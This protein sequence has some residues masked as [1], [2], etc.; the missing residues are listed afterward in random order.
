MLTFLYDVILS[1]QRK[2][3][4]SGFFFRPDERAEKGKQFNYQS[5]DQGLK[6]EF[7]I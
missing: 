3:S 7:D 5:E 4:A 2:N 6:E 1:G